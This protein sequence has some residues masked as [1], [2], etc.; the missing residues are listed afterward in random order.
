MRISFLLLVFAILSFSCNKNTEPTS[1]QNTLSASV[2]GVSIVPVSIEV[3]IGGSSI[4]GARTVVVNVNTPDKLELKVTMLDYNGTV[5]TFICDPNTLG[6]GLGGFG[7]YGTGGAYGNS[8]SINGEIQ[9][10]SIDK[11]TY[12]YGE[13]VTGTFHFDTDATG[14]GTYSITNGKFSVFVP[15]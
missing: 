10:S 7:A 1:Y 4:P 14:A 9:I 11:N 5:R 15:N 6:L 3:G 2:N 8:F 12:Q 13:V